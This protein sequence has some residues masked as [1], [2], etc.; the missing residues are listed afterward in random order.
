MYGFSNN[1]LLAGAEY[2]AKGNLIQSGSTYYTVPFVTYTAFSPSLKN[3]TVFSNESIGC[4][5]PTWVGIYNHYVNRIGMAAP[6]T[7]KMI[8]FIGAQGGGGQYGSTFDLGFETLTK[9]LD[10]IA[11]GIPPSGLTGVLQNGSVVLS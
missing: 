9:S 5:R 11:S 4:I 8:K 3:Y 10:N 2:Q 6:Y 1:R 7:L